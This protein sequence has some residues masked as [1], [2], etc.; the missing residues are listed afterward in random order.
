MIVSLVNN[1]VA[2][3]RGPS[4][5]VP[6]VMVDEISENEMAVLAANLVGIFPILL[7]DNRELDASPSPG[8]TLEQLDQQID[9]R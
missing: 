9:R 1:V 5:I 8:V 3:R 4:I 7:D 2:R 6:V